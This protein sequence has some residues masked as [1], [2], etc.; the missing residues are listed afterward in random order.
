VSSSSSL[1]SLV[2][3]VCL[4]GL[5][6][7]GKST[8]GRRLARQLGRPFHDT[9]QHVQARVGCSISDL[10]A[11]QG[12]AAFR[13]LEAEALAELL[14]LRPAGV[15]ATGGGIV[16]HPESAA[17]IAG[18]SVA[19]YLKSRAQELARRLQRDTTRPLLRQGDVLTNLQR[20]ESQRDPL[21]RRAAAFTIDTVQMSP[22]MAVS[23]ILMQLEQLQLSQPDERPDH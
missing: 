12:E 13:A 4:I 6:G 2:V 21:Y 16:T 9:D 1:P 18:S 8:I 7:V 22:S 20:L 10:F 23:R 17:R 3:P 14:A 15:V 5:P 19:I 11:R